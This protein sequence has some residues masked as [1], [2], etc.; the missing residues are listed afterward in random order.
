MM[1]VIVLLLPAPAKGWSLSIPYFWQWKEGQAKI[2]ETFLLLCSF[3]Y[4][5]KGRPALS[6]I[7]LAL[8]FFDPRFGIVA[9]PL[10]MMYNRTKLKSAEMWFSALLVGTNI[11]LLYPG[12]GVGYLKMVFNNGITTEFYPYALIPFLAIACLYYLNRNQVEATLRDLVHEVVKIKVLMTKINR[13]RK[14]V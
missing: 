10:F 8:A 5:N 13:I 9:L 3:Y 2:L 6:G 7:F 14:S 4:G 12:T 11:V 1:A